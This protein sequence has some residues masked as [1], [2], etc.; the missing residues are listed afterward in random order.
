MPLPL[1]REGDRV[2]GHYVLDL[3]DTDAG[4]QTAASLPV[5]RSHM[6]YVESGGKIYAV[7]GQTGNDAGLTTRTNVHVYDPATDEWTA[8]AGAP[9]AVSH[10]SSSTIALGGRILVFGGETDHEDPTAGVMAYDIATDTWD[11]LNNLPAAR[12]SGVARAIDGII[13]FTSGSSTTTTYRGV[14]V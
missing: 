8:L 6:G 10:V 4:W 3:D 13:Y 11:T 12:F 7:V 9:R 2:G 5:P 14:F 1:Q